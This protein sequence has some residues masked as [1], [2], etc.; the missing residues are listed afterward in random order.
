MKKFISC[1]W[2]T[3]AFRVRLIDNDHLEVVAEIKTNDGIAETY[4]RWINTGRPAE[5]RLMFYMSYLQEQLLELKKESGWLLPDVPVIISGMA[6]STIGMIELPYKQMP[7]NADGSDLSVQTFS[8]GKLI[9]VSGAC[10]D[11]DVLRGEETMLV[12]CNV[13]KSIGRQLMVFPGTHSKHIYVEDGKAV[14]FKTYMTGEFF[15]LLSNKSILANSVA[16]PADG[17][18]DA[19]SFDEGV[20]SGSEGNLLNEAFSIRAKQVLKKKTPENN[21]SFLSG[22]LIGHELRE[23]NKADVA[24]IQLVCG[25]KLKRQYMRAMQL[26]VSPDKFDFRDADQALIRGHHIVCE[27]FAV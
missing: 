22:L 5:E 4:Q 27:H 16:R 19:E 8:D 13:D 9:I 14:D 6:S 20:R 24:S 26:L 3:S 21:Y 17:K 12:G 15:D 23:V 10:T 2:G 25:S 7:F 1:D 18:D 11:K